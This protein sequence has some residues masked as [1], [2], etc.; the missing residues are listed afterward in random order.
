MG[1]SSIRTERETPKAR[2][3]D[4]LGDAALACAVIDME[5]I[6][7]LAADKDRSAI[8]SELAP[9]QGLLLQSRGHGLSFAQAIELDEALRSFG[10]VNEPADT[11]LKAAIRFLQR[12]D[13]RVA[14]VI[15]DWQIVEQANA[16]GHQADLAF[17]A[18]EPVETAIAA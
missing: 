10:D 8:L 13:D 7:T 4:M 16:R 5:E 6:E 14:D 2:K 9:V 18:S 15:A 3:I 12:T 17:G 1:S 11:M